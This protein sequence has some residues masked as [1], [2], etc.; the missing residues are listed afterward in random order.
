M[1]V[2]VGKRVK[3][4]VLSDSALIAPNVDLATEAAASA[5]RSVKLRPIGARVVSVTRH[6]RGDCASQY[7]QHFRYRQC[8]VFQRACK[9]VSHLLPTI[10]RENQ[11][12]GNLRAAVLI[13]DNADCLSAILRE[14]THCLPLSGWEL[15]NRATPVYTPTD[16]T[17][18]GQPTVT[19][20]R[21][22][23]HQTSRAGQVCATIVTAMWLEIVTAM[24]CTY[25]ATLTIE[26]DS[27]T[28][29]VMGWQVCLY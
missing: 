8:G 11:P 16:P 26:F 2:S 12:R 9:R 27:Q 24:C 29:H 25:L 13:P 4:S 10:A 22:I 19:R 1:R 17:V 23:R 20:A 28:T 5:H 21:S 18:K 14:L 6:I 3:H 7:R 15:G